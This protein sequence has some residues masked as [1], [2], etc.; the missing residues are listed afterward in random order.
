MAITAIHSYLVNPS[1]SESE[2]EQPDI[3]GTNVKLEGR[4]YDML[5]GV[6]EKA[7]TECT[8]DIA[9]GHDADGNQNNECRDLVL[10]Y[11]N[12]PSLP[13]GRAFAER[14]QSHTTKRSG[15]GLL[16][17]MEG[18]EGPTHKIVLS[19]FPAD[20]GILAEQK[21]STL[22]VAFLEKVFMKN[23]N[24][25]KAAVYSGPSTKSGFWSGKAIDKQ[26]NAKML[27]LS[28]YWIKD[29]LASDFKT[30]SAAGT[31]RLANAMRQ[32][33][34]DADTLD[35]KEELLAAARLAP[36][37]KGKSVS[38][39]SLAKQYS[40]SDEATA[41]LKHQL[42]SDNLFTEKFTLSE[43]EFRKYVA[44]ESTELS[45]GGIL[46]A[47]AGEFKKVFKERPVKGEDGEVE[48]TT[49]GHIVDRKIRKSKA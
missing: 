48:F 49:T 30:T 13:A 46:M 10:A 39:S 12:K 25:Y 9:F 4:L 1:K 32:A 7:D 34:A 31:K 11:L 14:L 18:K 47:P 21:K 6:Y 42:P 44:F 28:E 45:N 17:I 24:A 8:I 41:A 37:M 15:L 26:I 16:F 35:I 40:L 23:A 19:R 3:G 33:I 20:V 27:A 22:T 5:R 36:Q 2:D 43:S 29:F 38:M